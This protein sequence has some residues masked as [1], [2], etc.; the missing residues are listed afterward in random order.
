M[1]LLIK[2]TDVFGIIIF[3]YYSGVFP[4]VAHISQ[5]FNSDIDILSP[6]LFVY[7]A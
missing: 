5:V 4:L 1:L 6:V 7:I 3:R 2:A